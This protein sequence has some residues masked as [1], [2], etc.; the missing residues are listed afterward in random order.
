MPGPEHPAYGPTS[1]S[2]PGAASPEGHTPHFGAGPAQG[3]YAPQYGTQ[4]HVHPLHYPGIPPGQGG[5]LPQQMPGIVR[6][7]QVLL[8]VGAGF[9]VLVSILAGAH[10]GARTAGAVFSIGLF[11]YAG[12]ICAFRFG[13]GGHGTKVTAIVFT[14]IAI[15]ASLSAMREY[16]TGP[17][18]I[19][20]IVTVVLLSQRTTSQW[21]RR[22]R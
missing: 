1:P 22:P 15:A 4:P 11:W 9:F 10:D 14:S 17:A 12:A 6:A 2:S 5:Y 13:K 19:A 3:Y 16:H 18:A 7:A 20:A 21:F 8:F